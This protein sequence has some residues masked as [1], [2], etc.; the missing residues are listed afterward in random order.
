MAMDSRQIFG[1][2]VRVE[3]DSEACRIPAVRGRLAADPQAANHTVQ[4]DVADLDWPRAFHQIDHRAVGHGKIGAIELSRVGKR[5]AGSGVE[6]AVS[7]PRCCSQPC[8][9]SSNCD[10]K[11][12]MGE[13]DDVDG[14]EG[15]LFS[16]RGRMLLSDDV[17]DGS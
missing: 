9:I 10:R 15:W 13:A 5:R 16:T 17:G 3:P 14:R 4:L 2:A 11:P 12:A 8:A 6:L 7:E 1:T